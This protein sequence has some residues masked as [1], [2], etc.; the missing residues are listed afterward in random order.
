MLYIPKNILYVLPVSALLTTQQFSGVTM[1]KV[2][3]FCSS[4]NIHWDR[5]RKIQLQ[6]FDGDVAQFVKDVGQGI[7]DHIG[8]KVYNDDVKDLKKVLITKM[9]NDLLQSAHDLKIFDDIVPVVST[10]NNAVCV[11]A[12]GDRHAV[13]LFVVEVPTVEFAAGMLM[14]VNPF[15][16]IATVRSMAEEAFN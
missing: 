16:S 15:E 3:A 7:L 14:A 4:R 8:N 13:E 11:H 5:I 10:T 2:Y 6:K 1:S 12:D 9:G